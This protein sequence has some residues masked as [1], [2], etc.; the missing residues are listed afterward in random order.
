MYKRAI[1]TA[2]FGFGYIADSDDLAGLSM[3]DNTPHMSELVAGS[4][5]DVIAKYACQNG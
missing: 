4:I 2:L 1:P 5:S 3:R